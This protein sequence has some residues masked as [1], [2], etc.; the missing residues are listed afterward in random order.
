M[1]YFPQPHSS[2]RARRMQVS[3]VTP[4]T[5]VFSEGMQIS[6]HLQA[7]S[8]TGGS[9]QLESLLPPSTLVHLTFRTAVGPISAVA[10]MLQALDSGRQA[11]RFIGLDEGDRARLLQFLGL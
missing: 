3:D 6:G 11:F 7:V 2:Q 1:P 10:E 8:T 9:A 5:I 4:L